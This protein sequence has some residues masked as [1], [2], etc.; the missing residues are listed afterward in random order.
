MI[1]LEKDKVY[2]IEHPDDR[3]DFLRLY[4]RNYIISSPINDVIVEDDYF[5]ARKSLYKHIN[6]RTHFTICLDGSITT[7]NGN[8]SASGINPNCRI[9]ELMPSDLKDIKKAIDALQGKY[10]YN[11]KLNQLIVNDS[12]REK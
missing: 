6:F 9:L 8:Y 11:R 12:I 3:G 4:D 1:V 10:K 5:S 7:N 2:K